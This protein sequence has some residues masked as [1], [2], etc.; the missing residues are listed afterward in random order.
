MIYKKAFLR[1]LLLGGVVATAGCSSG[2]KIWNW[3]SINTAQSVKHDLVFNEEHSL[4]AD[5]YYAKTDHPQ[6][7]GTII[8]I[9]GGSWRSGSKDLYGF[10]ADGLGKFGYD[11]VIPSYRLYPKA[12]YPEFIQDVADFMQWYADNAASLNLSLDNLYLMGHSAGAYNAAMYLTDPAYTKPLKYQAF[13]GLAGPYDFFLPTEDPKY[14]PIFTENGDYNVPTSMPAKQPA[15]RIAAIIPRALLLHGEDDTI[16]TPKNIESF[17]HFLR[18]KKV[19]V[20]TELYSNAGH[21]QIISEIN[22]VPFVSH[23]TRERV[24]EFIEQKPQ[25]NSK[26]GP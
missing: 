5:I 9:H 16:V 22:N 10:L 3:M 1:I 19:D 21:K 11:V 8:F 15:E 13:I 18:K 26:P 24:I 6:S 20:Q 4:A 7:K 12:A 17:A 25:S 2:A 14:I 23:T